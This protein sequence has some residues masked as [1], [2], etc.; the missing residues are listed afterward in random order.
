[1][2]SVKCTLYARVQND[3]KSMDYYAVH[4]FHKDTVKDL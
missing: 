1:M 2:I 4:V 3:V